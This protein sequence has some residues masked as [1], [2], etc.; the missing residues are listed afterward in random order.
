MY[1]R[2]VMLQLPSQYQCAALL[3]ELRKYVCMLVVQ[4][5]PLRNGGISSISL[6]LDELPI[7]FAVYMG[8]KPIWFPLD[9][10]AVTSATP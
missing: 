2:L 4:V 5:L 8:I 6:L 9:R 1:L 7:V 10:R 3:S